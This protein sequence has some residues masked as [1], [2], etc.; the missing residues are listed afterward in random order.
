M[1]ESTSYPVND[2][3]L[4]T[5]GTALAGL[6]SLMLNRLA[7]EQPGVSRKV[8]T[9]YRSGELKLQLLT[10]LAHGSQHELTLRAVDK[11]GRESTLANVVVT[12]AVL[13]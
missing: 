1:A 13:G 10:T 4:A 7:R 2:D 3:T 11:E 5:Y 6:V 9:G 8:A 12:A